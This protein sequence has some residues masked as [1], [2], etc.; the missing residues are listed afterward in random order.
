M[1]FPTILGG[2]NSI[3]LVVEMLTKVSH[4][5]LVKVSYSASDI[6]RIFIKKIFRLHGLPKRI[7]SNRDAKFTSNF[8]TLVFQAIGTQLCFSTA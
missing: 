7:V 3:M 5:I 4:L 6:A 1:G 8:S 2:Y